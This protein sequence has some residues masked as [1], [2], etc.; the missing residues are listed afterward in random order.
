[1]SSYLPKYILKESITFS[2]YVKQLLISSDVVYRL[3]FN[4]S[5][6]IQVSTLQEFHYESMNLQNVYNFLVIEYLLSKY[7]LAQIFCSTRRL[8]EDFVLD[9]QQKF[10]TRRLVA[11][12]QLPTRRLLEGVNIYQTSSSR[13]IALLDVQQNFY[14]MPSRT[15]TRRLVDQMI[16]ATILFSK[17]SNITLI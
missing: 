4:V 9:V 17:I 16:W 7:T 1:M 6:I 10:S 11:E 14:L 12:K 15:F 2:E 8:V 5:F 13:K 3:S